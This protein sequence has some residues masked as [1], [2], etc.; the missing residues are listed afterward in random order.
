[1]GNLIG[2]IKV[3]GNSQYVMEKDLLNKGSDPLKKNTTFSKRH[4]EWFLMTFD[5]GKNDP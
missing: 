3:V 5:L 2:K 1:M 4:A